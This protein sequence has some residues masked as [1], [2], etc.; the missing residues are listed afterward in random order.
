[1]NRTISSMKKNPTQKPSRLKA[2]QDNARRI[3]DNIFVPLSKLLD[4]LHV[5]PIV[6]TIL[7]F[8]AGTAG[9]LCIFYSKKW[10]LIFLL[11]YLF[12]DNLDGALARFNKTPTIKGWWQDYI[13]DRILRVEF[14]V[15]SIIL[16]NGLV[17]LIFIWILFAYMFMNAVFLITKNKY[18]INLDYVFYLLLLINI[19]WAL[20]LAVIELGPSMAFF[21]YHAIYSRTISSRQKK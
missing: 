8:L 2:L 21:V 14:T 6:L 15:V 11:L 20:I 12:F 10:A 5:Q 19:Y 7:G 3:K 17:Q 16:S 18:H 9:A 13:I 1:M 4:K